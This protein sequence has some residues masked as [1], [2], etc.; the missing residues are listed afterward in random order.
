[1][2]KAFNALSRKYRVQ[3]AAGCVSKTIHGYFYSLAF[4]SQI[5]VDATREIV[6]CMSA[7]K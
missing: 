6:V 1:M 2:A 5:Q 4:G 7:H 3:I